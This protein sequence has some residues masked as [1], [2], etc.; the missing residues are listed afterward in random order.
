MLPL[1]RRSLLHDRFRFFLS[2]LGVA[3][4]LMLILV[5]QGLFDGVNRQVTAYLDNSPADL[6]VA[7]KGLRNFL[8]ARSIVPEDSVNT[9]R[10]AAG[11]KRA[12]PVIAQYVVIELGGR[13]EFMLLIGFDEDYGG[14][15][16]E[17]RDGT[18]DLTDD[19]IVLDEVT[20]NRHDLTPGST[21]PVLGR[22]ME[23]AGVSGGTSSWMTGTM[24]TTF[25]TASELL[26]TG[27]APSFVLLELD[28]DADPTKVAA[29]IEGEGDVTVTTR[30]EMNANDIELYAA[31]FRGPLALMVGIAFLVGVALVGLT[32][33]TATIER[34]K[35]YAALKAIG[36]GNRSLYGVV[37]RQ[38]A[39]SATA[40]FFAGIALTF[41][42][43][44]LLDALA[45]QFL[46][47][48]EPSM[49]AGAVAAVVAMSVL[50][51][52]LPAR[53]I[54]GIDPAAAFRKG[55]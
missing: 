38:A 1:A 41:A 47:A 49:V 20:A 44:A 12:V 27:E 13:R 6:V 32:I 24:F 2:V 28:P 23:V 18:A 17:M 43:K 14:G 15:P 10:S 40:G 45:P 51:A 46:V 8:G 34:A 19:Q 33:Y 26:S 53:A 3:L 52:L 35:E 54:A 50:A 30:A 11:V 36:I 42:T 39:F 25:D 22:D 37:L 29:A 7:E 55:A 31:V 5:L 48:I 4:S 9:A 21:M 16:W